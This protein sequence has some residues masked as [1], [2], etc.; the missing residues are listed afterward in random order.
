M[1]LRPLCLLGVALTSCGCFGGPAS[2]AY[3]LSVASDS[4]P[5]QATAANFPSL[6]VTTAALPSFLD[7]SDILVRHG[8]HA[9]DSSPTGHWGE[10]L[11][12][13][14]THALAA[15]LSQKLPGYRVSLARSETPSGRRLQL[16]V[17]SFDVYPDGHCVLAASWAIVQKSGDAPVTLGQG[18]FTTPAAGVNH[19]ADEELVSAMAD[20]I[21]QLADA[22]GSTM[23]DDH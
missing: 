3:V 18:V 4:A 14:I 2:R 23:A 7:N 10:R 13:G 8:P 22:I 19:A 12:L 1:W 21:S 20:T 6:Q 17:D 15:D 16:E 11:S 5:A 9:L